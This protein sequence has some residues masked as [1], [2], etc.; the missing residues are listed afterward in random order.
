MGEI[1]QYYTPVLSISVYIHLIFVVNSFSII[2][3]VVS[4]IGHMT[5]TFG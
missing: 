2:N 1:K 3:V 4:C 5:D